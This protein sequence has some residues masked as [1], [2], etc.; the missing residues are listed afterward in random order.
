MV[1]IKKMNNKQRA[2][3][4][5]K[6]FSKLEGN[7]HIANLFALEKI[8]DLLRIYKPKHV[9]EVGLGIG[10]ISYSIM[11]YLKNNDSKDFTYT[12]T[13]ANQFCLN[14]LSVNLKEH[15]SDL[16]IYGKI[17]DIPKTSLFDFIIIDG[18]DDA[19]NRISKLIS[20]NG[21]IFIEGDR[22]NQQD[23]L[24]KL[25]PKHKYVHSISNYK[26][27]EY[28]PFINGHWSGG[29][30]IIYVKPT[31]KQNVYWIID[32]F[33]SSYRNRITRKIY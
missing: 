8:L 20:K 2:E 19:L 30:K 24:V 17:E 16:V 25:F 11:D 32:K 6:Y 9:L 27:P 1:K 15:Y 3:K 23:I 21:I 29:G 13:E 5:Y 4:Y 28:G 26:E 22:K 31:V 12:G 33:I 18:S 10:S 7:Q 14:A